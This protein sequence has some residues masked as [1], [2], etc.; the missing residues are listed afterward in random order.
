MSCFG[1]WKL[2]ALWNFDQE[3]RLRSRSSDRSSHSEQ[4]HGHRIRPC[5]ECDAGFELGGVWTRALVRWRLTSRIH[6]SAK[7]MRSATMVPSRSKPANPSATEPPSAGENHT[8][9]K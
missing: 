2:L 4:T 6:A 8:R 5:H 9:S 3:E 1:R 7:T